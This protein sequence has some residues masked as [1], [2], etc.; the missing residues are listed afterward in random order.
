MLVF[1]GTLCRGFQGLGS[2]GGANEP[3]SQTRPGSLAAQTVTMSFFRNVDAFASILKCYNTNVKTKAKKDEQQSLTMHHKEDTGHQKAMFHFGCSPA[4]EFR[5]GARTPFPQR[6]RVRRGN[7]VQLH[8]ENAGQ[9]LPA[10][11]LFQ[12][13]RSE[14]VFFAETSC[15]ARTVIPQRDCPQIGTLFSGGVSAANTRPP[16]KLCR[17]QEAGF[18]DP[19]GKQVRPLL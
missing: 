7:F 8:Q 17:T 15:G 19:W 13:F 18:R 5:C 3:G 2:G 16:R 11:V 12:S 4:A 6:T 14:H 1:S 9:G 10:Q